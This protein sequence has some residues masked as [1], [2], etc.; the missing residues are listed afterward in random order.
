MVWEL[1]GRGL[2]IGFSIAAP[3]GPIGLLCIQRTLARGRLTGLVTGLGAASADALYGL[4]AGLGL[5]AA[6]AFLTGQRVWL[7]AGGGLFLCY[8]GVRT[9]LAQ[10]ATQAAGTQESG[11][12]PAYGSAV[13][14]TLA[15]PMTILSFVAVFA[16]LGLAGSHASLSVERR[17][18]L[19]ESGRRCG[20]AGIWPCAAHW[21]AARG[22]IRDAPV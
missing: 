11:L 21:V 9:F 16:G 12:W 17:L 19:G 4:I 14:L 5:S 2:I 6:A 18:T 1:F 20:V 8:L 10:P 13:M 3:V 7:S 15:N 22:V